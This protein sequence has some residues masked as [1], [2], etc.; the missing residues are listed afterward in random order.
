[1]Q[2]LNASKSFATD[3]AGI[4]TNPDE[5]I[6]LFFCWRRRALLGVLAY[7]WSSLWS[8]AV[9]DFHDRD[10]SKYSSQV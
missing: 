1:M 6:C 9:F 10:L 7:L 3:V 2:L 5:H 4:I 8:T